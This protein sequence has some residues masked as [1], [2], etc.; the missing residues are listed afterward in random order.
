MN[1][2][3]A[4]ILIVGIIGAIFFGYRAEK[5]GISPEEKR[6]NRTAAY[7]FIALIFVAFVMIIIGAIR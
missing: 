2:F 7:F 4:G 5:I 6:S 1:F 3:A